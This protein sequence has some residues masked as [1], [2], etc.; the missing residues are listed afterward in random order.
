MLN[1]FQKMEK[2]L[3]KEIKKVG[4]IFEK[5]IIAYQKYKKTFKQIIQYEKSF[6]INFTSIWLLLKI[7]GLIVRLT[8]E[9]YCK[10]WRVITEIRTSGCLA[11]FAGTS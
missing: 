6:K 7:G 11:H 5:K 3:Q 8:Q 4:K 10:L 1:N 2:N 9:H